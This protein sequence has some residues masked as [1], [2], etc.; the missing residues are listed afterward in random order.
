MRASSRWSALVTAR[1][2]EMDELSPGRGDLGPQ[3]WNSRARRFSATMGNGAERDPLFRHVRRAARA[4]STV[5]D[6][7]AGPGRF[8]VALAPHVRQVVAVDSSDAMLRLLRRR[9]RSLRLANVRTVV[10][11]WETVEVERADVGICS[12]VLPLIAEVAP[13]LEKLDA[14]CRERVFV[15]LNAAGA[16]LTVDTLWRHF[17]GRPRRPGPTYLDAVAVLAELGV[18]AEVD[19]VEVPTRSRHETL[20]AA[21][22]AYADQLLLPDAVTVRRE[23]RDVLSSWLVEDKDGLRPPLRTMPAAIVSWRPAAD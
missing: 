8:S 19:V 12:Y 15:Y 14:A 1:L 13:F 10:G 20:D 18:S 22:K 9:A 3:F 5:L 16:D 2:A 6:V 7:G 4:R 11:R 17:H 21:V 23:L